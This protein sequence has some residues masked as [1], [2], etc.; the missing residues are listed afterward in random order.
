MMAV[1]PPGQCTARCWV[2]HATAMTAVLDQSSSM[3]RCFERNRRCSAHHWLARECR[4]A[5]WACARRHAR[6]G[7]RSLLQPRSACHSRQA[8]AGTG[9]CAALPAPALRRSPAPVARGH[10]IRRVDFNLGIQG[11]VREAQTTLDATADSMQIQ[12]KELPSNCSNKQTSV[13]SR[14]PSTDIFNDC[15]ISIEQDG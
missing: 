2:G 8:P 12:H 5:R 15:P 6:P 4:R 7:R 11:H 1:K 13:T 9:S 10:S 3:L 14:P